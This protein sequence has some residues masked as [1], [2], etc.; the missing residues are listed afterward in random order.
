MLDN[1]LNGTVL[2]SGLAPDEGVEVDF[3]LLAIGDYTGTIDWLEII[4]FGL[5]DLADLVN[6]N[7]TASDSQAVG[8][9]VSLNDLRGGVIAEITNID[10]TTLTGDI[11]VS[12]T[13]RATMVANNATVVQAEGNSYFAEGSSTAVGAVI[14]TNTTQSSATALVTRADLTTTTSGDIL[15]TGAN[16]STHTSEV[17]TEISSNGTGVG[18][19]L[20][21]NSLGYDSQNVLFNLVDTLFGTGIANANPVSTDAIIGN[22]D[23]NSAGNVSVNA[24]NGTSMKSDVKTSA[25]SINPGVVGDRDAISVAGSIAR[26]ALAMQTEAGIDTAS[27]TIAAGD[28]T[29]SAVSNGPLLAPGEGSIEASVEAPAIAVGASAG[30]Q[31]TAIS[32]GLSV[33]RNEVEADTQAYVRDVASVDVEGDMSVTATNARPSTRN[34]RRHQSESAHRPL[35]LLRAFGRRRNRGQQHLLDHRGGGAELDRCDRRRCR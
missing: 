30:G 9:M 29:V 28:L 3:S 2:P 13:E 24:I 26:N 15:V 25:V 16:R 22:S 12:A 14:A 17:T 27:N 31:S 35:R 33:A 18:V 23:I 11:Q 8:G 21:F 32:V 6:T 7:I 19:T 34:P 10:A 1:L 4:D 20:A 5:S